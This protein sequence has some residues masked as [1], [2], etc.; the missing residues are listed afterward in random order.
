MHQKEIILH[1]FCFS[2]FQE[3]YKRKNNKILQNRFNRHNGLSKARTVSPVK[4]N[5]SPAEV[6]TR[7]NK[8]GEKAL[9]ES[10]SSSLFFSFFPQLLFLLLF[11]LFFLSARFRISGVF[12]LSECS[13]E[14]KKKALLLIVLVVEF[15]F[16]FIAWSFL[17]PLLN[18]SQPLSHTLSSVFLQNFLFPDL[19]FFQFPLA[20][21]LSFSVS[22]IPSL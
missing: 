19:S 15:I 5:V 17:P 8:R 2:N 16:P 6:E 12:L 11:G 1:D 21:N 13:S 10:S 22:H 4:G 18:P 14:I 9:L 3:Q 20:S 7:E